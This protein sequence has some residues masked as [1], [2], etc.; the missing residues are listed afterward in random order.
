MNL[1]N[2]RSNDPLWRQ[3]FAL[4]YLLQTGGSGPGTPVTPHD[5]QYGRMAAAG[6]RARRPLEKLKREQDN[7]SEAET[8][9]AVPW[10]RLV[11]ARERLS[12]EDDVSGTRGGNGP[13]LVARM[14][15]EYIQ[16][17]E[18]GVAGGTISQ[19]HRDNT[20]SWLNNLCGYWGASRQRTDEGTHPEVDAC[21][22]LHTGCSPAP[23]MGAWVARS[24]SWPS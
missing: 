4:G 7:G 12:W 10:V 18:R 22:H 2:K 13:W 9:A 23:G 1:V 24:R 8:S 3:R 17:C 16:Y 11:L 14:C 20:V 15:S 5:S 19:G 6:Q 21:T